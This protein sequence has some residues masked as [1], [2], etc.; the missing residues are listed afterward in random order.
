METF[1]KVIGVF[2]ET[3]MMIVFLWFTLST[4]VGMF[5][6]IRRNRSAAGWFLA[7]LT[8]ALPLTLFL[9]LPAL[10]VTPLLAFVFC[11]IE[12]PI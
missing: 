11:A 1:G 8:I 12:Q 2:P 3:E 7:P 5:A 4:A 10:I 6:Q 9:G